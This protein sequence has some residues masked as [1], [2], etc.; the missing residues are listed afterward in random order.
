[1]IT[2]QKIEEASYGYW[3]RTLPI[4]D[5]DRILEMAFKDGAKWAISQVPSWVHVEK[6]LP[7]V[8]KG[9]WQVIIEDRRSGERF[10]M[11]ANY[12]GDWILPYD[13]AQT[14]RV[15]H[16]APMLPLPPKEKEVQNANG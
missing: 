16:Y 12:D 10:L 3:L 2:E 5:P 11:C 6:R 1:M 14:T 15:T 13:P 4:G 9:P 8:G 7:E